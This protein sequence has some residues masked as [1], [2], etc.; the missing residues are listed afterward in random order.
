MGKDR[1]AMVVDYAV[2]A[3][4]GSADV[5]PNVQTASI[6]DTIRWHLEEGSARISFADDHAVEFVQEI[7]E[8]G[9]PAEAIARGAGTYSHVIS[10]WRDQRAPASSIAVLIIEP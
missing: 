4:V 8:P 9:A 5:N 6:G 1:T 7:A 10:V 2:E 3:A